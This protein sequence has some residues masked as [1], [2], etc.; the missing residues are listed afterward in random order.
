LGN[1]KERDHLGDVGFYMKIILIFILRKLEEKFWTGIV[2]LGIAIY[3]S[4]AVVKKV[5]VSISAGEAL[6]ERGTPSF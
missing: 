1:L 5:S 4:C 2:L 6:T 3:R